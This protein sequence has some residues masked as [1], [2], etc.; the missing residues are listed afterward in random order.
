MREINDPL[1]PWSYTKFLELFFSNY[2]LILK[3][4]TIFHNLMQKKNVISY[5]KKYPQVSPIQIIDHIYVYDL[6]NYD[7]PYITRRVKTER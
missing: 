5:L 3:I 2:L 1:I 4:Y 6:M 7:C